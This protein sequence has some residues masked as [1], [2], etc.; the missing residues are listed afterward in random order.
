MWDE[1]YIDDG[2][3]RE[4]DD[5]KLE[6]FLA[7]ADRTQPTGRGQPFFSGRE[8]EINAFRGM[9]RAL[10]LGRPANA[11]L[12]VE[13]AP[14][15]GKTALL[16]QFQ[17]ELRSYPPAGGARRW[18]PVLL[19]GAHAE[20]PRVIG[21][22]VDDG[23]AK[24]LGADVLAT[25]A[26]KEGGRLE[27]LAAFLGAA[28]AEKLGRGGRALAAAVA[29]RGFGA[30]G[31]HLGAPPPRDRLERMALV[32]ERRAA[33]W[34]EWQIVVL[35]DEAQGISAT[36][37]GAVPGTLSDI[38]QGLVGAHLSC[39]AFGLH[40]TCE[41]LYDVG[42]S[43]V[44]G[45]DH[46]LPLAALD[47]AASRMAVRR[48]FAQFGVTHADAWERAVLERGADWPQHLVFHLHG[49]LRELVADGAVPPLGDA[50]RASLDAALARGDKE[51]RLNYERRAAR[52][53][54]RAPLALRR[55]RALAPLLRA[56]PRGADLD[57][58]TDVL[59]APPWSLSEVAVGEFLR[60]AA[61]SGFM[62]PTA[63]GAR[64]VVGI[65]SF[66]DYL[67]GEPATSA[68]DGDKPR[69]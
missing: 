53:Q 27:R 20:C 32:A 10:A 25:E 19:N 22:A 5:V 67:L 31:M 68:G 65:P 15:A 41:A 66:A 36:V 61:R 28:A 64:C 3:L 33:H 14:G 55:A 12:V 50:R 54:R 16:A 11:T 26:G 24:Q 17:E 63:G 48:C 8:R 58:V 29:Q 46:H 51:R 18:L 23:I 4:Q 39:C 56:D 44:S 2:G 49:A 52:L 9:A 7:D 30:L 6:A 34:A 57:A 1:R 37:P 21:W 45:G 62:V 13:G 69:A 38:H 40:G 42:L 60:D 35:L 43:R 47:A 59:M